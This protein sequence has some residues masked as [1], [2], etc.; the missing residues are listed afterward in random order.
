MKKADRNDEWGIKR[1]GVEEWNKC[2]DY[3]D[4]KESRKE[5]L[6]DEVTKPE[7]MNGLF[8]LINGLFGE[9]LKFTYQKGGT[10]EKVCINKFLG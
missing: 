8:D 6:F 9:D 1:Y 5:R 4:D 10:N 3:E 7:N 2:C